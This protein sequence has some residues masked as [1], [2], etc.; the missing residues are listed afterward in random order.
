MQVQSLFILKKR[1][2][3]LLLG[4]I[5]LLFLFGVCLDDAQLFDGVLFLHHEQLPEFREADDLFENELLVA[6]LWELV[7]LSDV[8]LVVVVRH[9]LSQEGAMLCHPDKLLEQ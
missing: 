5:V 3:V 4:E 9:L 1:S 8:L 7:V 6:I 2:V